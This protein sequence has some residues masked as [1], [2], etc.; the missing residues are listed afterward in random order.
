MFQKRQKIAWTEN[1]QR[2]SNYKPPLRPSLKELKIIEKHLKGLKNTSDRKKPEALILGATPEYRDILAKLK[3]NVTLADFNIDSIKSMNLLL[4][5]RGQKNEKIMITD[6]L[7]M[8]LPRSKFDVILA[9]WSV[10]NLPSF[11]DYGKLFSAIKK[12]L[13][14]NGLFICRMNVWSSKENSW[15]VSKIMKMYEQNPAEKFSF[16]QML[17]DYSSASTRN[18][19]DF[20]MSLEPFYHQNM[21]LAYAKGEMTEKQFDEFVWQ[22]V[23]GK[24]RIKIFLTI[25]EELALEKLFKKYFKTVIPKYGR[26]YVYSRHQPIYILGL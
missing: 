12:S 2:W 24:Y 7:K 4:K 1:A 21:P 25:P 8:K 11:R 3:F 26:D 22:F 6:W 10:N 14:I 13:K 16:L 18:K 9:D 15:P 17:Q 19:K 23:Q 5:Y 20:T